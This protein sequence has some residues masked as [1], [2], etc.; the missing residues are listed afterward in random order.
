[1]SDYK[2]TTELLKL[3]N[4][5]DWD[6]AKLEWDSINIEKVKESETCLCGH[7]PISEVCILENK[8]TKYTIRVGN[9][10]VKKFNDK[11]DKIF[12][13]IKRIKEDISKS[14]NSE[15]LDF[16]LQKKYISKKDSYF[17]MSILR[18]RKLSDKQLKWKQDTN[19]KIIK[20]TL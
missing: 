9:C 17:Y 5:K 2:L 18:K 3:S 4:S 16:C 12:K 10:C 20:Y 14:V 19:K 15:T 13:A 1:M 8:N 6:I 7:Y 11:P